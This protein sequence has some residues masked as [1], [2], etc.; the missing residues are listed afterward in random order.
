MTRGA[1]ATAPQ[2]S[3]GRLRLHLTAW[4]VGT[5]FAILAVLGGAMFAVITNRLD[6]DVD[7]SL[8]DATADLAAAVQARGP[9][10]AIDALRIPNR[11]LIVTDTNGVWL[12]GAPV[13]TW[14]AK[15]ARATAENG[16]SRTS[17]AEPS[18]RLL[19]ALGRR[20]TGSPQ[21]AV[22][23]ALADE[24]ELED[25]YASLIA[26]FGAGALGALIL[27]AVGGWLLARQTTEPV[28]RAILHM[29]RFMADA[30][31]ELRTPITVVRS[32]AEVAL[33]LPRAAEDYAEALR[34]IERETGRLSRIVDD[35]LLLARADVGERPI[36]RE[37]VYLDDVTSDAVEAARAIA[38]RQSMRSEVEDFGEAPVAGDAALLRQLVLILL[39]N[40]IKYSPAGGEVRVGVRAAGA[41]AE[42]VVTDRG[43]GITPDQLSHVFER[44][45]RGDPSRSRAAGDGAHPEG[46]GLG[47]SIAQWIAEQHGGVIRI[48]SQP[49]QGTRVTVDLPLAAGAIAVSSP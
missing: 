29:R 16:V 44:F 37:R 28:E 9:A 33:Q 43:M 39:D 20:V 5:F 49:G 13:E 24:I 19:R 11:V 42:L 6:R 40:A 4:Y 30:A 17:H 45:F 31:H 47:L 18:D 1:P 26:A 8:R 7:D 22:A 21:G 46:A 2:Q 23:I 27:V 25:K 15:L 38:A 10:G 41:N 3:L 12:A 32:R 34:A 48:A 36:A 35:L 14:V